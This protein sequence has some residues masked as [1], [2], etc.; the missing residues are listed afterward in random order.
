MLPLG[1]WLRKDLCEM[2]RDLLSGEAIRRRGY[3]N[4][5]YV[6][7]L[8][9]EHQSGRRNFTDQIYALMVLELWHRQVTQPMTCPT[10][11]VGAA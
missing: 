1:R 9:T 8:L 4:P 6:Q 7:W 2:S 11:G 3:V 10:M 5:A